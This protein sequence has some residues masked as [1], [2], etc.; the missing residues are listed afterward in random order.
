[1]F[2]GQLTSLCALFFR[3]LSAP[4]LFRAPPTSLLVGLSRICDQRHMFAT[5]LMGSSI[6]VPF[7]VPEAAMGP[8]LREAR[9]RQDNYDKRVRCL[10]FDV[11]YEQY[12]AQ[13]G[14][15]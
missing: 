4:R 10:L 1:M 12:V 9:K 15:K 7:R 2:S 11:V 5:L 8:V 6:S 14:S 3:A 13:R